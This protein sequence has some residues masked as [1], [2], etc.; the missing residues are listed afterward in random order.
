MY[1]DWCISDLIHRIA[2]T[3]RCIL[4]LQCNN[5][6]GTTWQHDVAPS[7]PRCARLI[8]AI[9]SGV[10]DSGVSDS[11]ISLVVVVA[12]ALPLLVCWIH[13]SAKAWAAGMSAENSTTSC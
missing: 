13:L 3:N 12:S 10:S 6:V 9:S 4:N 1:T 7:A 11:L 5:N 8:V 2:M